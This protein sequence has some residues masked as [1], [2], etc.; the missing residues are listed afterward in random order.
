MNQNQEKMNRAV[1]IMIMILST[2]CM[3]TKKKTIKFDFGLSGQVLKGITPELVEKSSYGQ[4]I[5]K[6]F[7]N[8]IFQP[9]ADE[10]TRKIKKTKRERQ[11]F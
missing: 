2:S 1:V 7:V 6:D 10:M 11:N 4:Y 9:M 5:T 3:K 8:I